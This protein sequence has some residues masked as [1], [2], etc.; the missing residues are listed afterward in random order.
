MF[1]LI[2]KLGGRSFVVALIGLILVILTATTGF[3]VKPEAQKWIIDA[4]STILAAHSVG[5]GVA[6][7][8]SKGA[9][10]S[11]ATIPET[12]L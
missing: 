6:D 3:D 9:T 8:L 4:V 10:S 5:R 2:G 12:V 7:G 1:N 11:T